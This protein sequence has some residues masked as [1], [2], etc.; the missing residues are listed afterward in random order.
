VT[1]S[2]SA[3]G[4][5][6][7]EIPLPGGM[8]GGGLVVRVGTT[9]RRP[10]V[11]QTAAVE[12]FLAHLA[13]VGFD[14]A[15]RPLG[16]D[17]TGRSTI[18]WMPGD[19]AMPPFPAWVGD[20]T[21]IESVAVLQRRMHDASRTYVPPQGSVWYTPNLPPAPSGAIVCHN[22]LCVENVVFTDGRASAFIDFDFAA[23]ADPLLDVAIACRHWVPFKDPADLTDG[24][25][26]VD[27]RH[28]F[29]RYCEAYGLPDDS[30]PQVIDH[31]LDF[32]DRALVTMRAKA[33]E[34]L[35]LYVAV[36]ERGYEKQNRR[37]HEWLRR[38]GES[39][40]R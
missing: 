30:R 29:T 35:P 14:G 5:A 8:G 40:T 4:D 9:V 37:S 36:W 25:E 19:V 1:T 27:Q 13:S 2:S 16:R 6:E 23:P 34:G 20:D 11:A 39:I 21:A 10:V 32:L 15:P 18:T 28:R 38:F 17:T 26:G 12:A 24:F 33:H 31:G 22:D 7:D 3:G